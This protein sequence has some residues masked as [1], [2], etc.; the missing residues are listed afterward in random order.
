MKEIIITLFLFLNVGYLYSQTITGKIYDNT[1]KEPI[2]EVSV[3]LNGTTYNTM[4]NSKGEFELTFDKIINT[5]LVISRVGY[6]VI[7][8]PNPHDGIPERIFL[9]QK[10]VLDEVIVEPKYKGRKFTRR[11]LLNMFQNQFI[12]SSKSARLCKIKNEKEI[13]LFYDYDENILIAQCDN[14]IIIENKYLKYTIN[15]NL[16]SFH[17]K[18]SGGTGFWRGVISSGFAGTSSFIDQGKNKKDIIKRRKEIYN[19]S[20]EFFLKN[21]ANN[22][23]KEVG[24]N[25]YL[26]GF[27]V[28]QERVLIVTDTLSMKK[29]T[30]PPFLNV[31]PDDESIAGFDFKDQKVYGLLTVADKNKKQSQIAFLTEY[32]FIDRFGN[33][34]YLDEDGERQYEEKVLFSGSI[35]NM[36]AGDM[37]PLDYEP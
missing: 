36:R 6:N 16:L 5:D 9:T 37:L 1:T 8:I 11:E 33:I 2:P 24:F 7:S 13:K 10:T 14:P 29:V 23:L 22:T 17:V 15:F 21:V 30:I 32:F 27:P 34:S 20:R 12:G 19:E 35:G 4:T 25:F 18:Y 31:D 26:N 28:S 3:Y